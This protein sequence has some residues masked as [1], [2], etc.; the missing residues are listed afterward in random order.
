MEDNYNIVRVFVIHQH[1]LAIGIHSS[2]A[3]CTTL[4]TP[5][6]PHP[7]KLS[8]RTGFVCPVSYIRVQ[9]VVCFAYGNI[10]VSMLFS[11]IIPP[12]PHTKSKS[13][14]F[15]S[16]S[17]LLALHVGLWVCSFWIPY[18]CINIW[19]L[20]F[21]FGLISLCIIGSRFICFIRT[22]SSAYLFIA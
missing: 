12:S 11:Q 6:L 2:L 16:V 14:F 22:D 8:Q 20:S 15:T 10:Y 1:E 3:S 5:S 19:Y 9:I 17:P 7:S 13:L 18:T 4:P 21:S